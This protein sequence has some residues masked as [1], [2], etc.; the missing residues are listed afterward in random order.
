LIG[1]VQRSL[2]KREG[3]E[4]NQRGLHKESRES[5][6]EILFRNFQ[7]SRRIIRS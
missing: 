7:F 6:R 2:L 1:K 4:E 5:E 3:E